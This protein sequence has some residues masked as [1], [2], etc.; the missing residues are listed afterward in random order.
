[1]G[2][3]TAARWR[4]GT[5]GACRSLLVSDHF[6]RAHRPGRWGI[7][8]SSASLDRTSSR[9]DPRGMSAAHPEGRGMHLKKSVRIGEAD[10]IIETG[11]MAKQ[12][13]GS[14]VV[15]YGDTL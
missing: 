8:S 14:V 13:D 5:W 11:H 9:I 4:D 10:L 6:G 15:R 7:E 1:M 12:A 2:R 3:A